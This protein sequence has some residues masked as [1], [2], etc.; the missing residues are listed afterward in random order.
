MKKY[1]LLFVATLAAFS[2]FGQIAIDSSTIV[3]L[4]KYEKKFR[5][6]WSGDMENVKFFLLEKTDS[7]QTK[8]FVR[9]EIESKQWETVGISSGTSFGNRNT[10]AVGV[11]KFETLNKNTSIIELSKIEYAVFLGQLDALYKKKLKFPE[12]EFETK[13]FYQIGDR[14]VLSLQFSPDKQEKR[15]VYGLSLDGAGFEIMGYDFDL[16]AQKLVSFRNKMNGTQ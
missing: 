2:A 8:K 12:P 9:L 6:F 3:T 1:T 13:Y 14:I 7:G 15:W 5:N 4:D 16:M 10:W 11:S